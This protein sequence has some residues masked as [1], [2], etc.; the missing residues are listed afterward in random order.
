MNKQFINTKDETTL[1]IFLE[2]Q[3]KHFMKYLEKI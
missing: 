3:I 2:I 1:V